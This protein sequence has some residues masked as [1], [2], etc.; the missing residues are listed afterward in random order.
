MWTRIKKKKKYALK[1]DDWNKYALYA[2]FSNLQFVA[3]STKVSYHLTWSKRCY[4]ND[5][6]ISEHSYL[7]DEW[8]KAIW[9]Q[10]IIVSDWKWSTLKSY[11][12]SYLITVENS[13]LPRTVQTVSYL[14]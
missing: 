12:H 1:L 8:V 3:G 2:F 11:E 14:K 6:V 4:C 5:S 13:F 7:R 9:Q 10:V